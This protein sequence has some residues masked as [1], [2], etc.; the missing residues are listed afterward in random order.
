[1]RAHD[2]TAGGLAGPSPG[3]GA[4]AVGVRVAAALLGGY[5]FTWG[6]AALAIAGLA[7]LG[8]DFH[9]GEAAAKMLAFPVFLAVFLWTFAARR[10]ARVWA[11]LAGGGAAM[12]AAAWLLQSVMLA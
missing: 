8:A 12:T 7:A 2:D 11:V 4:L 3:A 1:M 6:F 9:D 10:L 5:A